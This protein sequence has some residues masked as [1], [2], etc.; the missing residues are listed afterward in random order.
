MA[1]PAEFGTGF[2]EA[3]YVDLAGNPMT[4]LV[5][6]S[7]TAQVLIAATSEVIIVPILM[8]AVLDENG[9]IRIELPA[10]DDPDI[11]PIGWT[12]QVREVFTGFTR[13]Y[14]ITL[15]VG[16]T[17]DLSTESPVTS[18]SG[19][20]I[21]RGPRGDSVV[22]ATIDAGHL[23]LGLGDGGVV[24]DE[25][26]AGYVV[27]PAG[28]TGAQGP[29]GQPGQT[30]PQ[31]PMGTGINVLGSFA[32]PAELPATGNTTGD[33]FLIDANLWVWDG[34]SWINAGNIQGPAGEPGAAGPEG[35]AGPAGPAGPTGP[36]GPEGPV[37][38]IGPEGPAGTS[39]DMTGFE[40]RVS[41]LE[42]TVNTQAT[43]AASPNTL[44][45]R[46]ASGRLQVA[47]PSVDNDALNRGSADGRY[48]Q[49]SVRGAAG[50]LVGLD[51][52]LRGLVSGLEVSGITA[53]STNPG[54]GKAWW[55]LDSADGQLK[56][57]NASG[58][59]RRYTVDWGSG[60]SFPSAGMAPGDTYQHTGLASVMVYN[61]TAPLWKQVDLAYVSNKAA[62]D[63]MKTTYSA[64]LYIGFK[65]RTIDTGAIYEWN[66]ADFILTA[67]TAWQ[68]PTLINGWINYGG[69]HAPARYRKL[70]NGMVTVQGLVRN[71]SATI[72][73]LP[74]AYRPAY[75]Q[76]FAVNC[77]N[78]STDLLGRLDV[79][80]DGALAAMG[81]SGAGFFSI[82]C[83][84]YAEG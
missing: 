37:G 76:V 68:I 47:A 84:F 40:T 22:E 27:G 59:V 29:Q 83:S 44:A 38:P 80:N 42:T 75:H 77:N 3:T 60:T 62:V 81:G 71:G 16:E 57:R 1:L 51:S 10:T 11:N 21:I 82:A 78:G 19:T 18:T 48:L 70:A 53:P 67:D 55:Y 65:V 56:S 31:G 72:F 5:Q 8:E 36:T 69:A 25:V 23:I 58:I 14:S 54:T 49:S 43:A 9:H 30:G 2:V 41:G 20:P 33:A 50:G 26:D 66:G 28:P 35:P 63:T 34:D 61:G 6:F 17:I 13:T 46:D 74:L 79:Q 39:P 12:Y 24:N 7:T 64:L 52:A 4:G 45:K 32:D 15:S 73:G